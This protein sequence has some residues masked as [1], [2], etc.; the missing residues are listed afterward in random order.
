MKAKVKSTKLK[1]VMKKKKNDNLKG[2]GRTHDLNSTRLKKDHEEYFRKQLSD[3]YK[4]NAYSL[5]SFIKS[6]KI[7]KW[8]SKGEICGGSKVIKHSNIKKL[9]IHAIS[10]KSTKPVG[11]RYFYDKLKQ[12][13]LPNFLNV[14]NLRKYTSVKLESSWRPPGDL[15]IQK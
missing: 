11:Y 13:K 10:N 12:F 1:T 8:N 3:I 15:H 7:F 9:I 6:K 2:E 14:K 5:F 4:K